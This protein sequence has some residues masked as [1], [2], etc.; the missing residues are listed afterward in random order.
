M[1][2]ILNSGNFT[3]IIEGFVSVFVSDS[4]S[5]CPFFWLMFRVSLPKYFY[6]KIINRLREMNET[7][8]LWTNIKY[9]SFWP[10]VGLFF[11]VQT[12]EIILCVMVIAKKM[13]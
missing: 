12:F 13:R 8:L 1:L 9:Y 2:Y 7:G 3:I 10:L 11:L 4:I 5:I 6:M